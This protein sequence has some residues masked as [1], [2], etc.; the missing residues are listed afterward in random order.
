[1]EGVLE[2]L[3][4][5]LLSPLS[6]AGA[7]LLLLLPPHASP[8]YGSMT[9]FDLFVSNN[10][11]AKEWPSAVLFALHLLALL[12]LWPLFSYKTKLD[13]VLQLSKGSIT[14]KACIK[15]AR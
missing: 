13:L 11:H 4:G 10:G 15:I 1:M 8:G 5:A 2:A 6:L 7:C 14:E 3:I 12:L 9:F